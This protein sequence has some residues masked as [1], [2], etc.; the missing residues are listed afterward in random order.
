MGN[1]GPYEDGT[2][3]VNISIWHVDL[4][5]SHSRI[6]VE[7]LTSPVHG[8]LQEFSIHMAIDPFRVQFSGSQVLLFRPA[9]KSSLQMKAFQT[10]QVLDN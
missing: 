10:F 4:S 6:P 9:P 3:K 2:Y 7:A 1:P 5:P 8:L